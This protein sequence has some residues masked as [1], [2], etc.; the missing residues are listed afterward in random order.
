MAQPARVKELQ[1]DVSG[2]T[3][4]SCVQRVEKTLLKQ[5]GVLECRVNLATGEA[6][7]RLAQEAAPFEAMREAVRARGYDLAI[8]RDRTDDLERREE[9][10]W[11]RRLWVAWPLSAVVMVL[12]MVAMDADWARVTAF[13][14]A[15]PVQFWAGWPFLTGAA[16]RARRV[17]A[18]MDTLIALGTLTAYGY[19][20]WA[21]FA[22]E[23]LYFDTAALIIS[24]LL[25]GKYLETRA[26]GR[27]S[28]AMKQLLELGAK[29]AHVVRGG[30]EFLM[31]V[32]QVKVGDLVRVRPGEKI[33]TD[34]VVEEGASTVDESMLTG[35]SVPVEKVDGDQVTG[36]TLN[37]DGTLLVRTTRVGA[38][39]ALAQIVKLVSEAQSNKAPIQRLADRIAGVFVPIVIGIAAVTALAWFVATGNARDAILPA[40]SVLIIACPCAMGLATPAAVMVGT[41]RGAQLGVLIRGGEVLEQSRRID[42]VIFDKTG[43]L[44]EGQMRLIDVVGEESALAR[45]AATESSSEHPIARAVVDGTAERGV[46]ALEA[47]GFR[48][49]S[50]LGVRATVQGEDVV[51]GRR[52]FLEGEGF[53]VPDWLGQDTSR[54]EAEGKTV[55]LVGWGDKARAA[56]A[57]ADT[58]RSNSR[59]TVRALKGMGV[60]VAMITG[61]NRSTAEAIGRE[62]GIERVLA[63]VLPDQKVAEVRRLQEGGKVVAMVGDGIN[64]GPALA[65][66]DLG[67][68]IGTGADVA[69][70][71]SDLTLMSGDL[72]GVVTAIEL[73]RRTYRTIVQNLF[74]AFGYNVAL[75]PLAAAGLLNPILAG[76]A[77]AFSSVSVV[78]NSLRLRRFPN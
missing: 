22:G 21:L 51:V 37:L 31:L 35:E 33:P 63:E 78:S 20:V 29:E 61:D 5:P 32:D 12:S 14:L 41:G 11:L 7:V 9:R 56:L 66:A 62:A 2:M 71:A 43:T 69:I 58:L 16:R 15:T 77:M 40:I 53:E 1:L 23:E 55:F 52:S 59:E 3:C 47:S 60:E 46:P 65:Q 64:D 57:V 6:T 48:A 19:S 67:V 75:I 38:D 54:L 18:N 27:A 44:T 34:G 30:R 28:E 42:I 8:H 72:Q 45:A 24:F 74:W 76:A 73:S 70:E 36:A 13:V 49:V 4:G 17:S 39:T 25:L 26:R 68:A 50:G 10:A